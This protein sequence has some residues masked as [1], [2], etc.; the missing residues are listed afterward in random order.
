MQIKMHCASYFQLKICWILFHRRVCKLEIMSFDTRGTT[1]EDVS[2]HIYTWCHLCVLC[3]WPISPKHR[4]IFVY[5]HLPCKK[6][7]GISVPSHKIFITG[8]QDTVLGLQAMSEFSVNFRNA[9]PGGSVVITPILPGGQTGL[10]QTLVVDAHNFDLVQYYEVSFL[11]NFL[12][13]GCCL[14]FVLLGLKDHKITALF[15]SYRMTQ[16]AF[17]QG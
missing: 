17:W 15:C 7:C 5:I 11:H 12:W 13:E 2:L 6:P 1:G 9:V 16:W 14:L 10:P 8:L 3:S 4:T